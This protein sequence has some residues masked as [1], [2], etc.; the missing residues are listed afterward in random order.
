MIGYLA[1]LGALV[2]AIAAVLTFAF[3]VQRD[4]KAR[5]VQMELERIQNLGRLF[6]NYLEEDFRL[7]IGSESRSPLIDGLYYQIR[8]LVQMSYHEHTSDELIKLL[9][10]DRELFP[11]PAKILDLASEYMN[12]EWRRI[13]EGM[14]AKPKLEQ[15]K[16]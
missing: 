15:R 9:K 13:V 14:P 5:V 7:E 4:R 11:D 12:A 10:V 1:A 8:I 3:S 2:A 16:M 6:S